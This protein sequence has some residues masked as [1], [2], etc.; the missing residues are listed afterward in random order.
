M[1]FKGNCTAL[2]T[3]FTKNN[4]INFKVLKNLIEKQI[5]AKTSAILILGTTGES[6]TLSME[7]KTELVKQ[8]KSIINKRVPLIVGAGSNNTQEA[9]KLSKTFQSLGADALL[10]ITPYYNKATQKGLFLHFK[11]IA[12]SVDI[13]IILY[14][15]PSRTGVNME[16]K[17]VVK[18]A[19]I[20]N[21]VGI[22]EASGNLVQISKII[23]DAP[24]DFC[25]YSGD[26]SLTLPSLSVGCCGVFSVAANIFP[27]E[28]NK[29]CENFF[30][31]KI[32]E[33]Q[34]LHNKLLGVFETLFCEVN[35]IPIKTALNILGENVGGLRLPLCHMSAKNL[36]ILKKEI[37]KV[38]YF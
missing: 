3:P 2:V 32:Q 22:K 16:P 23:K 11:K 38:D 36:H 18:L 15:V 7:E 9:I 29:I 6:S 20:F 17:T 10:V 30:K 27:T 35:P 34:N 14:N 1:L 12:S 31:G 4:K 37:K 21:I 5:E 33:A 24:Y 26:D 25:V 19:K 8:A 28:I 13:P